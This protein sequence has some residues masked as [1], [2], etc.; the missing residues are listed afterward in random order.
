MSSSLVFQSLRF[1]EPTYLWL[2][3]APAA[4]WVLWAWRYYERRR[5]I[6]RYSALRLVPVRERFGSVGELGFWLFLLSALTLCILSLARPQGA[7]PVIRSA[8]VDVVLLMDGSTSMRVRDVGSDRW[9]RAMKWARTFAGTLSWKGDRMALATFA[10]IAT[11]QIRLTRDPNNVF[12]F[13]DHLDREPTFRLEDDVSWDTNVED[14][15]YWGIKLVDTDQQLYGRNKNART[16]IVVSDGQ[17]WTGDV[18]LALAAAVQRGI[19]VNVVGVGTTAGALIPL[20][21]DDAGKIL[22][23]FEP[24][25]AT[26]DRLSLRTIAQGGGGQYFELGTIADDQIATQIIEAAGKRSGSQ[27]ISESREELYWY[28]LVMAAILVGLGLLFLRQRVQFCMQTILAIAVIALIVSL[29][30]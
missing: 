11:P 8:G 1:A 26:L 17:V 21:R 13:M 6:R 4:L 25:L 19:T 23:D 7:V 5:D 20:P 24:R 12:F 14:A 15:I 22:S 9:Q 18:R 3:G 2:L 28:P 10:D 16:F 29:K 30:H 27:L